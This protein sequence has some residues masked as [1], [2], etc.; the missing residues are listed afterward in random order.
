MQSYMPRKAAAEDMVD[1]HSEEYID[2][3]QSVTPQNKVWPANTS[4]PVTRLLHL[5]SQS[6][7]C[8]MQLARVCVLQ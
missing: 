7:R 6:T 3:L 2:F 8:E 5:S 4:K 1:F